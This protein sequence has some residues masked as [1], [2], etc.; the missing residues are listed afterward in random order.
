MGLP[1]LVWCDCTQPALDSIATL[2]HGVLISRER[3]M[4]A[5]LA[6][7]DLLAL[8]SR[9]QAVRDTFGSEVWRG[10][11]LDTI[12]APFANKALQGLRDFP[13]LAGAMALVLHQ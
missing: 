8:L 10:S 6:A 11:L 7:R 4:K 1:T 5:E 9:T 12:I 13:A 2:L 3:R